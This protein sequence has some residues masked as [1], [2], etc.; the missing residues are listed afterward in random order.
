MCVFFGVGEAGEGGGMGVRS[1]RVG[2]GSAGLGFEILRFRA[3]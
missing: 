2:V 1:W 3:S